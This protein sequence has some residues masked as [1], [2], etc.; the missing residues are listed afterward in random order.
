MN[1]SM[2]G[3]FTLAGAL[4]VT[5]C[6]SAATVYTTNDGGPW[7][8]GGGPAIN[9]LEYIGVDFTITTPTQVTGI[10]G[11]IVASYPF[12]SIF[13]AILP[14]NGTSP[15]PSPPSQVATSALAG[16]SLVPTSV[17]YAFAALYVTLQPGNYAL[18]FGGG[19]LANPGPFGATGTAAAVG[20]VTTSLSQPSYISSLGP[21]WSVGM[22]E[23]S[24]PA[25]NCIQFSVYD[26]DT[27]GSVPPSPTTPPTTPLPSTWLTFLTGLA[28][29]GLL[30]RRMKPQ[31]RR[32]SPVLIISR[33]RQ[34]CRCWPCRLGF[35]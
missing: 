1:K 16:V 15:F 23:C 9:S 12:G 24:T 31:S 6:A 7:L 18:I 4:V 19:T 5:T 20:L 33:C 21:T 2:A 35:E 30:A 14:L 32:G 11:S 22:F 26:G 17:P 10:S 29:M 28:V 13:G 8:G 27:Q 25:S 3:I 34:T